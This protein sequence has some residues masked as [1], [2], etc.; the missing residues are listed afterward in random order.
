MTSL[1]EKKQEFYKDIHELKRF[2]QNAKYTL[3]GFSGFLK[4]IYK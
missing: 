3:L 2:D 4:P 1:L